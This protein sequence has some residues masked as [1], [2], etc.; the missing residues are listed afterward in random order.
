MDRPLGSGHTYFKADAPTNNV[1]SEIYKITRIQSIEAALQ[2][3]APQLLDGLLSVVG[4]DETE[5]KAIRRQALQQIMASP[6]VVEFG[7]RFEADNQMN[8]FQNNRDNV[9]LDMTILTQE[10]YNAE[11]TLFFKSIITTALSQGIHPLEKDGRFGQSFFANFLVFAGSHPSCFHLLQHIASL[12]PDSLVDVSEQK[13]TVLQLALRAN[14]SVSTLQWIANTIPYKALQEN[15]H[16]VIKKASKSK[17]AQEA[18]NIC[19]TRLDKELL[20]KEVPQ[21]SQTKKSIK[22]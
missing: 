1:S 16:S 18:I 3:T 12:H 22:L 17:R 21:S 10:S 8:Y 13:E 19:Q 7:Y 15:V 5:N 20:E 6:R 4:E 9:L 11:D 14:K 2:F